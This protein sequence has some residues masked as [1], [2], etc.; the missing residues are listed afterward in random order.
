MKSNNSLRRQNGAVL[1]VSLI[2]LLVITV[3]AI[4]SMRGTVLQERLIGNQRAYQIGATGAESSLREAE[5]RLAASL[6]PPTARDNCSSQSG[7]CVLKLVP[8]D[9]TVT[10][11]WS[12]WTNDTNAQ[13]YIGYT[14]D[15][16]VL[17][18]MSERPRWF[19]AFIGFD[20]QNSKGTVEVTDIDDRRRGVGPYYYQLNA[21]ARSDSQRV[22][23]MLQSVSVQRY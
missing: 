20:P 8:A 10:R 23:V 19:T 13:N 18:G 11:D 16:N 21:A 6:G 7:L 3:L 2:M 5:S 14:G 17:A 9:G 15:N 4:S 22:M 12:W 1:F